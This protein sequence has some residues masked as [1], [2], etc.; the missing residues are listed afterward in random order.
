MRWP[1]P[2]TGI[3]RSGHGFEPVPEMSPGG[4]QQL[5][6]GARSNLPNMEGNTGFR[7]A[8]N[9]WEH[10]GDAQVIGS[11]PIGDSSPEVLIRTMVFGFVERAAKRMTSAGAIV[12]SRP[13]LPGASSRP[14]GRS[15]P[16]RA[17]P[18]QGPGRSPP[19]R[20]IHRILRRARAH[21]QVTASLRT[22]AARTSQGRLGPRVLSDACLIRHSR[23]WCDTG[24]G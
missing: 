4:R 2:G 23:G 8:S 13:P 12:A 20:S 15:S 16:G 9:A 17:Y 5:A 3:Q 19:W 14:A 24:T 22:L 21:A 18:G 10:P 1:P 7:L 11:I 6:V